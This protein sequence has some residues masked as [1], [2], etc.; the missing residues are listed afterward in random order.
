MSGAI[1]LFCSFFVNQEIRFTYTRLAM[2]LFIK[3]ILYKSIYNYLKFNFK[4]V[5]IDLPFE[6]LPHRRAAM[7]KVLSRNKFFA[8]DL[9]FLSL[10]C[11]I[12]IICRLLI[13]N[14][15]DNGILDIFLDMIMVAVLCIT[16]LMHALGTLLFIF[17]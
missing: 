12:I 5:E 9:S 6:I 7:K 3:I 16:L 2:I 14:C 10:G 1:I 13:F 8:R 4:T 11:I 17:A 15:T